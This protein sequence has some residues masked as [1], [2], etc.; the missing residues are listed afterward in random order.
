MKSCPREGFTLIELVM[1]IVVVGIVSIPL[2]LLVGRHLQSTFKSGDYTTAMNLARFEMEKVNNMD[3][4]NIGNNSSSDDGYDIIRTV[5]YAQGDA[6]SLESV[7]QVRVDVTKTGSPA[8]L[9]N[10]VTYLAKNV[11]YGI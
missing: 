6:F 4:A 10:L 1:T 11:N 7:K 5:T 8:V 3:Y 9:F 2:S